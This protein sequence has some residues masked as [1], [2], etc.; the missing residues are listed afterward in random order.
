MIAKTK[1]K[2]LNTQGVCI[3]CGNNTS[4]TYIKRCMSCNA[5]NKRIYDKDYCIDCGIELSKHGSDLQRCKNCN[6]IYN[7]ILS[8]VSEEVYYC[9]DCGCKIKTNSTRCTTC[10]NKHFKGKNHTQYKE[11]LKLSCNYCKESFFVKPHYSKQ[12]YCSRKCYIKARKEEAKRKGSKCLKYPSTYIV[13][14]ELALERD[15]YTC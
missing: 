9:K 11:E 13:N 7:R 10:R 6:T 12:K 14:R 5:K 1:Y 3:E 8:I 2:A 4:R 15:D